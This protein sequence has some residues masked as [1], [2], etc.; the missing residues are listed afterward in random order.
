MDPTT[1][2]QLIARYAQGYG[3]VAAL[4]T[5]L[6]NAQLDRVPAD[7]W[8]AR[9]IVHHLADSEM[10]S[11][12]RLRRLVAEDTPEIIGY[13]EARFAKTLF[14]D[15]PIAASLDALKGARATS[16]EILLRL[17]DEQW[18]RAGTHSESGRYSIETWLEIYAAHAHDHADQ[19]R[20]AVG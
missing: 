7:G 14:Y 19:M 18:Q 9:Q 6:T 5:R 17:G 13:D 2:A 15:R 1:R 10:T 12:I 3:I 20:R 11:A 8:S 16:A 4:A